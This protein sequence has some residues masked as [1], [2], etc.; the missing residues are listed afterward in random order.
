KTD[1]LLIPREMKFGISQRPV[2]EEE[3]ELTPDK[4][5]VTVTRIEP[6]S[7]A[8][9]IQMQERDIIIAINRQPVS[10]VDDIKKVQQTLKPGDAVAFRVV[11][12]A[13]GNR[14]RPGASQTLFLS[15]TLPAA[16]Q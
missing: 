10:S 15:G 14:G 8:D 9:E 16:Q 5:G 3:R 4:R 12:P 7:F 6:G 11:R 2:S 1:S 13:R